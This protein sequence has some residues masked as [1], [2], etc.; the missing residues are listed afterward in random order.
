MALSTLT[1]RTKASWNLPDPAHDQQQAKFQRANTP[2]RQTHATQSNNDST[3]PTPTNARHS[4]ARTTISNV[5]QRKRQV[6]VTLQSD[7]RQPLPGSGCRCCRQFRRARSKSA[8]FSPRL[9]WSEC[10]QPA[11]ARA[12]VSAITGHVELVGESHQNRTTASKQTAAHSGP[13]Q[14]RPL[15]FSWSIHPSTHCIRWLLEWWLTDRPTAIKH[16]R[17]SEST[18]CCHKFTGASSCASCVPFFVSCAVV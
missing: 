5:I 13:K 10:G 14:E 4:L 17:G 7:Q 18:R 15:A 1:P 3:S 12:S 11:W 9:G 8:E 2:T 16:G 6:G